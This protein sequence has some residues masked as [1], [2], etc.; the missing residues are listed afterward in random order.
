MYTI[1]DL[2]VLAMLFHPRFTCICVTKWNY[3]GIS[4]IYFKHIFHGNIT[5]DGNIKIKYQMLTK[6][7]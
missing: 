5:H 6:Q 3:V 4:I 7:Q 1:S 2:Y